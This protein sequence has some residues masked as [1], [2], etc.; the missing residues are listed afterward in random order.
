M[1]SA[2]LDGLARAWFPAYLSAVGWGMLACAACVP[3]RDVGAYY[4]RFVAWCAAVLAA[5]AAAWM[6]RTDGPALAPAA[7]AGIAALWWIFG[8]AGRIPRS[9]WILL[10]LWPVAWGPSG[11][12]W[13]SVAL[14]VLAGAVTAAVFEAMLL[15]H[16]YL[17]N[18]RLPFALLVRLCRI[19]LL[20]LVTRALVGAVLAVAAGPAPLWARVAEFY[21]RGLVFECLLPPVRWIAGIAGAIVLVAMAHACARIRSNQSATGILYVAAGVTI[22]GEM[23]GLYLTFGAGIPT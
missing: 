18:A 6:V 16:W 11:F 4:H 23:A 19:A 7:A 22:I 1:T 14:V 17:V 2:A 21:E 13:P 9:S 10:A 3:L 8:R 12:A 5:V 20:L 15:G